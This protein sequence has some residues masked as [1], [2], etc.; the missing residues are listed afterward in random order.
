M[1][2]SYRTR[3][4][5]AY[6]TGRQNALAPTT[7]EGLKPR[8]PYLKKLVQRHFPPDR[9]ASILDLGCGYGALV[10]VAKQVGY[11]NIRGVD[12][13][14]EQI[15]A[16]KALGIDDI[17]LVNVMD[18]L[19]HEGSLSL[20]C[21]VC[22]D[23]LEHFTKDELIPLA[24]AIYRVVKPRGQLILHTPNAESLF[25]LKILYGD[26]THE[27]AFTR[28]SLSQLLFSSGFSQIHFYEDQP[29]AHGLKSASRLLLWKC[30][31]S[32]LRLY[33]AAETGDINRDAIFSL[34]LLAVARK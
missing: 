8:L 9:K 17:Q 19:S 6:L 26:L 32:I 2:N 20:D 7:L 33:L 1:Q 5:N 34:N 29:V 27:M 10:H 23:L 3:I 21:V 15:A 11:S 31:R 24:D 28:T 16:A 18:A 13:S 14:P 25:G 22:F 12:E 4:Y 30:F